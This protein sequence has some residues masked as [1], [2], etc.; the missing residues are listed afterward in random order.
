MAWIG[1][2]ARLLKF[3]LMLLLLVVLAGT[4]A[5]VFFPE[6]V[7]QQV[8]ALLLR[9]RGYHEVEFRVAEV[10]LD[11]LVLE[12]VQIGPDYLALSAGSVSVA[13]SPRGLLDRTLDR[14]EVD[15]LRAMALKGQRGWIV[16][17]APRGAGGHWTFGELVVREGRMEIAPGQPGFRGDIAW[18]LLRVEA[19]RPEGM[20]FQ[21]EARASLFAEDLNLP[22]HVLVQGE[23]QRAG[24]GERTLTAV[25]DEVD[26]GIRLEIE[27]VLPITSPDRA[28]VTLT[29]VCDDLSRTR[30]LLSSILPKGRWWSDPDV[31]G[32]ATITA[33]Y[34]G[35]E[36]SGTIRL[37]E[38]GLSLP[39]IGLKAQ[40]L[41][42]ELVVAGL[43]PLC[44]SSNQ[45]VV[46]AVVEVGDLRI[47]DARATFEVDPPGALNVEK[48]TMHVF[49]GVVA[50]EPFSFDPARPALRLNLTA[51]QLALAQFSKMQSKVP[52]E[53]EGFV[54]GALQLL[55]EPGKPPRL[56]GHLASPTGA[57]GRIQFTDPSLI[58]RQMAGD[59]SRIKTVAFSLRDFRYD[60]F[61]V[62]LDMTGDETAAANLRL[63]GRSAIDKD[64]PPINLNVKF[65]A[66]AAD[67]LYLGRIFRNVGRRAGPALRD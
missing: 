17:G 30:G 3:A 29:A 41:E 25:V 13:F 48:A 33:L 34:A 55:W 16:P 9:S 35:W 32:A 65:E 31:H 37:Q 8:L 43:R 42:T 60:H 1:A 2:V 54:D 52:C 23:L 21:A 15:G 14:V 58:T 10:G 19:R 57:V 6:A 56:G 47:T 62:E 51:H 40:G 59:D 38:A 28:R 22:L 61:R 46:C 44:T 39:Q 63:S 53:A 67:V 7:G 49:G 5:V 26:A 24:S 20:A 50:V 36:G 11:R 18:D 45:E 12:S 4:A 27:A 64:A 66:D